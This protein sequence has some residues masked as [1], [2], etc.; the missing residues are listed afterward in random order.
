M[1]PEDAVLQKQGCVLDSYLSEVS[2]FP[3]TYNG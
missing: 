2:V 1:G 3:P